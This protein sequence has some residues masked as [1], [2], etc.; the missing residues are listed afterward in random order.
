M[1]PKQQQAE[2]SLP[3]LRANLNLY[4]STRTVEG[5]PTWVIYDPVRHR[6][7]TLDQLIEKVNQETSFHISIE[8]VQRLVKFLSDSQLL[9]LQGEKVIKHLSQQAIF[10]FLWYILI[11]F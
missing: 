1:P 10:V 8:T 4:P 11:V 9:K 3:P 2:K 6:Y 7:F 5:A